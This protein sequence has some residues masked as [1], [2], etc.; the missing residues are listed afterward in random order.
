MPIK[1]FGLKTRKK[2]SQGRWPAL[3]RKTAGLGRPDYL[4]VG[5]IMALTV[6]GLAMLSSAS[7]VESFRQHQ[8]TYYLLR[9]QLLYGL[10]PGLIL[11]FF[12]SR[13]NYQQLERYSIHFMAAALL[14]LV[15]VFIPGI[16]ITHGRAHSWINIAGVS[17]QPTELVK[18]L[19]ILFL[20][21]WFAQR[22]KDLT[23]DFWNGLVPFTA[24]AAAISLPI[25][26][27]PD[28]GTLAVVVIITFVMY[29]IAGGRP[30]HLIGLVVAGV[31]ALGLLIAQA[32]Y[33]V[34]RFMTFL[35][36]EN[37]PGG[38]GYQINQAFLAIGSGGWLGLGFGQSRQK[39]AYLPEVI[40]DSIFA[41]I[42]EELGFIVA[43]AL[44]VAFLI[45]MLRGLKLAQQTADDYGRYLAV[46]IITWFSAQAFLN[47]GAMVGLLPL[48]GIP[49]P[50]IS[51]GGTALASTLAAA[52]I[53]VSIS[54]QTK[55]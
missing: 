50:F 2:I 22:G 15:L 10:L 51:Y 31:G 40:G 29:A 30:K 27:Q 21:A 33:R 43:A 16:G 53:L 48:T 44:I 3:L 17:L 45:L 5:L 26:L 8:D 23:R 6:F 41:V 32:P 12:F 52:G 7:S 38:I 19:I 13:L 46:G 1:N 55:S 35:H 36:P 47:I 42:A 39:F 9:H 24:I 14:V 18:L 20:A 49:L 54:R 11:F 34:D 4:L 28:I 37:D 25:V